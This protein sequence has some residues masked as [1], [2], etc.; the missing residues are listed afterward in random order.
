MA[1]LLVLVTCADAPQA[2]H[3]ARVLVEERLAACGNIIPGL[4]SIYTWEGKVNDA[5][6]T[7]LLLKTNV[8]RYEE[9]Q[10]R[11]KT[12]HSYEVPEIIAFPIDRGL[13][14]Y[15]QWIVDSVR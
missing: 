10:A 2:A 13:P 4:R 15:L 9:V 12:L 7:L 5:V 3:I 6:E 1:P 8:E 14:A 11:I